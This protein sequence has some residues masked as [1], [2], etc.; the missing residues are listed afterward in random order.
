MNVFIFSKRLP[1]ALE[2]ALDKLF[3]NPPEF[4]RFRI[5][6]SLNRTKLEVGG[7][8]F[9]LLL[10][11]IWSNSNINLHSRPNMMKFLPE[12]PKWEI[13]KMAQFCGNWNWLLMASSETQN[14]GFFCHFQKA[15]CVCPETCPRVLVELLWFWYLNV[16]Y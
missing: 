2:Y 5:R 10:Q 11:F 9:G 15:I 6:L 1:S 12:I 8:D 3:I 13:R 4:F 7:G 14:L 16:S